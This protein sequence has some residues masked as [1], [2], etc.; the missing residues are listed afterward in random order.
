MLIADKR[1]IPTAIVSGYDDISKMILKK[2]TDSKFTSEY[3]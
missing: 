3:S 2:K 1:K